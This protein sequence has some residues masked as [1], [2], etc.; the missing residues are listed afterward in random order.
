M[1]A[2]SHLDFPT[3]LTILSEWPNVEVPDAQQADAL[4]ERVRQVLHQ[5]KPGGSALGADLPPLL[6]QILLRR[7]SQ[8]DHVPWVRVPLAQGWPTLAE[9]RGAQFD[10][11]DDG[12]S[13]QIRPRFP[14]L[15]FLGEQQDLYD[16]AFREVP[17][18]PASHIRG[19]PLLARGLGLPTYTGHGQR[20]AVRA[21]FHLPSSDTLIVN[22]PTGSGKSVMAHLPPLMGQEGSLTLAVV[23]TV[24]LAID[25]AARMDRLF[26]ARFPHRERPPL[27][28]HSGLKDEDRH[29]VWRAIRA[30]VQPVLFTSPEAATG[31]LRGLLEDAAAAARLDHVVIDEA[32]LVIGW[33]NG[34]RPAFQLLPA[35]TRSLRERAGSRPMRIVLASATLTRSTTDALRHLFGPP[36]R[37]Y[38]VAAVHLRPEPRYAFQLCEALLAQTERVLE[39]VR[40]APRPFILYVT[41]PDEAGVWLR[42]LR[43]SGY[44]RVAEF[45]GST[46]PSR[47]DVLLKAWAANELDGMV[48]TSAFGLGVD[49]SDVRTVIH[50]TMP[51]SL[52]RYY[53]EVGR[54][55]RDGNAGASLL[56]FTQQD[57][58][59]ARGMAG[60]TLIG[61]DT[62]HERWSLMID[63]AV[64]DSQRSD[65]HW[66]DV[67]QLPSHLRIE[68]DTSAAWNIRTLTLMARAG[69][70]QLVSLKGE[71]G[72]EETPLDVGAATRAAVRIL[73]EGHLDARTF[74]RRMKWARDQ[75]WRAS[76]RGMDAMEAVAMQRTEISAALTETYSSTGSI[77]SPVTT[78]CGGCP[79]HWVTREQS[80]VHSP[81]RAS[82]LSRFAPRALERFWRMGFARAASNLLVVD[83]PNDG[84]YEAACSSL[85]TVLADHIQPH[86]WVVESAYA[87]RFRARLEGAATGPSE[88]TF[89]DVFSSE[90]VDEWR[91]GEGEV[92]VLFFGGSSGQVPD[93]IWLSGS[94]LDVLVIPSD[95]PQPRHSARR[96]IDTIPHVH[97]VDLL[98]RL[99]A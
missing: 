81:P 1:T 44:R 98:E 99:T 76:G 78:C 20:E 27:A 29:E 97:A 33:G 14:R 96:F 15:S 24:A 85:A 45:T 32:H 59:Q 42:R 12:T 70:I 3:L 16:D 50:A 83:V 53:Q 57:V 72:G 30:G 87:Q 89:I 63:H 82:R 95:A 52:D 79:V 5:L 64:P 47:R 68:S 80:R 31:A 90:S 8:A 22:L 51:E 10:L 19:D 65:V 84:G 54:S 37:T 66:V 92:R 43:D 75:I 91:G 94:Q 60:A 26:A 38:V 36:E 21:L 4:V 71:G 11:L 34:F 18:R 9:W 67:T 55:G 62:G 48:A 93:T 23:P 74:A 73:D 28:Y 86:T 49:K 25:Q 2:A 40:L 46:S 6:R 35:L 13:L 61:D 17:S 41:R 56:L 58:E 7:S 88:R 39:A 77:W 69:I